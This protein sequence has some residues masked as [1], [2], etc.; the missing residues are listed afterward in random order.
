[1]TVSVHRQQLKTPRNLRVPATYFPASGC[2]TPRP[3]PAGRKASCAGLS[4]LLNADRIDYLDVPADGADYFL[5]QLFVVKAGDGAGN[6]QRPF[7]K[8]DLQIAQLVNGTAGQ[9]RLCPWPNVADRSAGHKRSGTFP[10]E[11]VLRRR[12]ETA[13]QA[14]RGEIRSVGKTEE[15]LAVT[16]K[17]QRLPNR[18]ACLPLLQRCQ[19]PGQVILAESALVINLAP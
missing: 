4:I 7:A 15:S 9:C 8:L 5:G 16:R 2:F 1:M 11:A 12:S 17:T 3:T 13:A 6:D 14:S 18:A 19:Y 10:D